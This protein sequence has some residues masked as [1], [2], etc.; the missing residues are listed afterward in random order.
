MKV[1]FRSRDRVGREVG[2]FFVRARRCLKSILTSCEARARKNGWT[3]G[4]SGSPREVETDQRVG[5]SLLFMVEE[6]LEL[7]PC[8]MFRE[9]IG[10]RRRQL[11]LAIFG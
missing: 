3:S 5:K 2:S 1:G 6:A 9:V 8:E 11:P 7:W 10:M 4:W